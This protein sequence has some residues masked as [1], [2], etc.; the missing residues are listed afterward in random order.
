MKSSGCIIGCHSIS[1]SPVIFKKLAWGDVKHSLKNFQGCQIQVGATLDRI[2]GT[3]PKIV[4][5][6]V[7]L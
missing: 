7:Q 3:R 4:T 6:P 1:I 5:H 2:F